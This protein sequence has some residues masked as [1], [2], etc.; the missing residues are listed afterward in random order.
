MEFVPGQKVGAK[1]FAI[2]SEKNYLGSQ[3]PSPIYLAIK[4]AEGSRDPILSTYNQQAVT[5]WCVTAT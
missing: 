1:K 3:T 5:F 2:Q 4:D